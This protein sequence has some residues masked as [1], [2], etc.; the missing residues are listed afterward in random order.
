[1]PVRCG[2]INVRPGDIIVG[3]EDGIAVAP[4]ERIDEVMS[5]ATKWQEDRNALLPLIAKH[6]SYM[7]AMQERDDTHKR[8][9]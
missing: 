9:R 6:D 8:P 4:R 5:V 7:K 1:V 3:D 2:G